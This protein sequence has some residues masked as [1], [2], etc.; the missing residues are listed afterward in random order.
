[1]KHA[2]GHLFASISFSGVAHRAFFLRLT[3]ISRYLCAQC[4]PQVRLR[5]SRAAQRCPAIF[6]L[7]WSYAQEICVD[8]KGYLV[9]REILTITTIW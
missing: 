2:C 5:M 3:E 8:S 1:M 6:T 7:A 4:K 9:F